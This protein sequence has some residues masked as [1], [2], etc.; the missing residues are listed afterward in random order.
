MDKRVSRVIWGIV[1][2]VV[3]LVLALN[4]LN[5]TKIDIFFDG[6]WTLFIIVPCFIGM[7]TD[8]DKAG[9][10]IGLLI[11]V[12]LFLS[13]QDILDFN[14]IWKLV[15]PAIIII[16]GIKMIIGGL[17]GNKYSRIIKEL[18]S[19]GVNLRNVYAAFSSSNINYSGEVFD[20]AELTA[21]FGSVKLNLINAVI[22]KD[23]VINATAVFGGIDIIIPDNINV[24][25]RSTSIFGGVS[26]KKHRNSEGN[27]H[28]IYVNGTCMFGGVDIK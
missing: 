16:I 18:K 20:G 8:Y 4:A 9:N 2:L 10:L 13:C 6:W 26:Q 23:C 14:L 27:V 5:I 11:G 12:F 24:K 22:D 17:Q 7:L 19:R 25:V 3:G 15:I 28:T 21:L 1:L